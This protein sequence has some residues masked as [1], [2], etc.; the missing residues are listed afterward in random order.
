[1]PQLAQSPS[2]TIKENTISDEIE[3][4]KIDANSGCSLPAQPTGTTTGPIGYD[5]TNICSINEGAKVEI[6]DY[7]YKIGPTT[8][9]EIDVKL[10]PD[11]LKDN[12]AA[13]DVEGGT[14]S[15]IGYDFE[16]GNATRKPTTPYIVSTQTTLSTN[17]AVLS[18]PVGT[19]IAFIKI[20][21]GGSGY[22][23]SSLP[24]I[25]IIPADPRVP[26]T[27]TATATAIVTE[28]IVTR[29]T[30]TNAG[31]GYM[32][33][34]TVAIDAPPSGGQQ[35]VLS[36][37]LLKVPL[38]IKPPGY[39]FYT[40][41]LTGTP[42]GNST[43][44]SVDLCAKRC[45]D[46]ASCKGFNYNAIDKSC[47]LYNAA[48]VEIGP[49]YVQEDGASAFISEKYV[50][51]AHGDEQIGVIKTDISSLKYRPADF[52]N[53]GSYCQDIQQCNTDIK[54][55]V[56]D[57]SV[58]S[59]STDD[60]KSCQYC[61][62]RGFNR[63]AG[64]ITVTNEIGNP[65]TVANNSAAI[66]KLSFTKSDTAQTYRPIHGVFSIAKW[67][68]DSFD[69][70]PP[71]VV[72]VSSLGG[73]VNNK[74][75]TL[76]RN[77]WFDTSRYV[78]RYDLGSGHWRDSFSEYVYLQN[79]VN[80]DKDSFVVTPVDYVNNGYIFMT[81]DG[82]HVNSK[83]SEA[84]TQSV[85]CTD[86]ILRAAPGDPCP[87]D[88]TITYTCSGGGKIYSHKTTGNY[89][90]GV[91]KEPLPPKYSEKYN[92]AIYI[93]TP[94]GTIH[95]FFFPAFLSSKTYYHDTEADIYYKISSSAPGFTQ[96]FLTI[97]GSPE[98]QG[99]GQNNTYTVTLEGSVPLDAGDVVFIE[100]FN[101]PFTVT[102]VAGNNVTLS[103]D[104][105]D[106]HTATIPNGTRISWFFKK[107]KFD[108]SHDNI[109]FKW[110]QE[111][112]TWTEIQSF[113]D[114]FSMCIDD[115]MMEDPYAALNVFRTLPNT[116]ISQTGI[117]WT[118]T[119]WQSGNGGRQGCDKGCSTGYLLYSCYVRAGVLYNSCDTKAGA[120]LEETACS[121]T[122]KVCVPGLQT[123]LNTL[124]KQYTG[125][126]AVDNVI[127]SKTDNRVTALTVTSSPNYASPNSITMS[128]TY[129][130]NSTPVSISSSDLLDFPTWM[131]SRLASSTAL[132]A[133]VSAICDPGYGRVTL[134][135]V[136]L[137]DRCPAGTYSPGGISSCVEC[138][139]GTYCPQGSHVNTTQCLPGYFCDTPASQLQCPLGSYCPEGSTAPID[140]K[141]AVV[142]ESTVTTTL[143]RAIP[144]SRSAVTSL[145]GVELQTSAAMLVQPKYII[146]IPGILTALKAISSS[147]YD[148]VKQMS[149]SS[150]IPVGTT[151]K[152]QTKALYC[153]VG[154]DSPGFCPAGSRCP[155]PTTKL[156]CNIGKFC[157][158][159]V[160]EGE[161]CPPGQ[162]YYPP[163]LTTINELSVGQEL[164]T[165]DGV[166][167][168]AQCHYCPLD[169]P[170]PTSDKGGCVC[171]D[172]NKTWS[173]V[174]NRCIH[175]CP[176]GQ[177]YNLN[178][179]VCQSC[180][181]GTYMNI[182]A[183]GQ[184]SSCKACA[185]N[186][187]STVNTPLSDGCTCS[188]TRADGSV[189]TNGTT[190][191][192]PRWNRCRVKCNSG[193]RPFF[194][195]CY[196]EKK[197]ATLN[198]EPSCPDTDVMKTEYNGTKMCRTCSMAASFA[199]LP[200][201]SY[202][203]KYSWPNGVGPT[204]TLDRENY[205]CNY[206]YNRQTCSTGKS[207]QYY[208]A[209][210]ERIDTYTSASPYCPPGSTSIT[211]LPPVCGFSETTNPDYYT[212]GTQVTI[213]NVDSSIYDN[214]PTY[215]AT[216][217]KFVCNMLPL[218]K[219]P[220]AS[221]WGQNGVLD[222]S[223]ASDC[224]DITDPNCQIPS[225]LAAELTKDYSAA[226]QLR[227]AP[228]NGTGTERTGTKGQDDDAFTVQSCP[229]GFIY[230]CPDNS[231]APGGGCAGG[232][233]KTIQSCPAGYYCPGQGE[234][235]QCPAGT[236]CSGGNAKPIGCTSGKFCPK[237]STS[238]KDEDCPMG[239]YCPTPAEKIPCKPGTYSSS[240]SQ[241]S[242]TACTP[243]GAGYYCPE[244]AVGLS[245]CGIG[246]YCPAG[247]GQEKECPEG[248]YC[249]LQNTE[250]PLKC[251]RGVAC[252]E[253]T[254]TNY[255]LQC[256]GANQRPNLTY[257]A[258]V[259]CQPPP[260]GAVYKNTSDCDTV[261]C[262]GRTQP[263][264]TK[265]ECVACPTRKDGYIWGSKKGC[266]EI[267]C[268]IGTIPSI[269]GTTCKPV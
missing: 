134:N 33:T 162:F 56:N 233:R 108:P 59:F 205:R 193:Y 219:L 186:F 201:N 239:Y 169:A 124:A 62:I 167:E 125:L 31:S 51:Q 93:L 172:T 26:L 268:P 160:Y 60:I 68:N 105:Q 52:S 39:K 155:D 104:I 53:Q 253:G 4:G 21:N 249:H 197:D 133:Q 245:N 232:L 58:Q 152:I 136:H 138:P 212:C 19:S 47:R 159:G 82:G 216:L 198:Y 128:T 241:T 214:T 200:T 54:S 121:G 20:I 240:S 36:A 75:G 236:Y 43:E 110:Y 55:L 65:E 76:N 151:V 131:R 259:T 209:G 231:I 13:C 252:P 248:Y 210:P 112:E 215:D 101:E 129:I 237:G 84:S 166:P 168:G 181:T 180:P 63:G 6:I 242:I 230:E 8:I 142:S 92:K 262:D 256:T 137:C 179:S 64:T 113:G 111:K 103:C 228:V 18:K 176:V 161:Q 74:N 221:L 67:V 126:T 132:S 41:P 204:F 154:S 149:W 143:R 235:I 153:P 45:N 69:I 72:F 24:N 17:Q 254:S 238:E 224:A 91:F 247:S 258:C 243:C 98:L 66:Q 2:Y 218:K 81:F 79:T 211:I 206:S 141:D 122:F 175:N 234:K 185:T 90:A 146:S 187:R 148:L 12:I 48:S 102:V 144:V 32:E 28:G 29:V 147:E 191:W 165:Y 38:L 127:T 250:T 42:I 3:F 114:L 199:I 109:M 95:D 255:S 157:V 269:S 16:T 97:V 174:E 251:P 88:E 195:E 87:G 170:N 22:S 260:P 183:A 203:Y 50:S 115:G 189:L 23:S 220:S 100:I 37:E 11:T 35:A 80:N 106:E 85:R 188:T 107:K 223:V 229:A 77:L 70:I 61:P 99:S 49:T 10:L 264:D 163:D 46:N 86:P 44:Q 190:E 89:C 140:C 130:R 194:S 117:T 9:P 192:V 178:A 135:Q 177:E 78:N 173:R 222:D 120:V 246:K 116:Q 213:D 145:T 27:V 227:S 196:P 257:T 7:V 261:M 71:Q 1:M 57:S 119:E 267:Q 244:G 14:C 208:C 73:V 202:S 226:I 150:V 34:P 184:V 182:Q 25:S 158:A 139:S 15:F 96:D 30:L 40:E 156:F 5:P 217:G 171:T 207:G 94:A 118:N 263:N 123:Q 164:T 83:R 225:D 265:T 266:K